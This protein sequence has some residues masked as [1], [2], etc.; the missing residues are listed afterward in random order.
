MIPIFSYHFHLVCASIR[1]ENEALV[2]Q[3]S[4][5][6]ATQFIK[7]KAVMMISQ[8]YQIQYLPILKKNMFIMRQFNFYMA[9]SSS[10]MF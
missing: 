7:D 4:P 1:K 3:V 2:I 6:A 8:T 5:A 9:T 10:F